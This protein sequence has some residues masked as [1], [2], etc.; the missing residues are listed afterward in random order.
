MVID[1]EKI[2]AAAIWDD[3]ELKGWE[4]RCPYCGR[5]NKV[6]YDEEGRLIN[7]STPATL[8]NWCKHSLGC[9]Q[10]EGEER[11]FTFLANP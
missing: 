10:Y 11:Q 2:D 8:H 4:A 5:R 3:C 1:H 7:I 9:F 6:F